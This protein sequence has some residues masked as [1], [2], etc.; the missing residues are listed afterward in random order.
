MQYK[1]SPWLPQ[2]PPP[3]PPTHTHH[4]S[5]L[6][7]ALTKSKHPGWCVAM[8][9]SPSARL[10][11][12]MQEVPSPP[13]PATTHHPIPLVKV[14]RRTRGGIRSSLR[15]RWGAW[16]PHGRL[17]FVNALL[18]LSAV[19]KETQTRTKGVWLLLGFII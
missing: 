16:W 9:T 18:C 11:I 7:D 6:Q 8:Q 17:A 2:D 12:S 15:G 3:P 19:L 14:K 5:L 10:N 13:T 1:P 4:L